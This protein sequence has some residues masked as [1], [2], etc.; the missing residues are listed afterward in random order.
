MLHVCQ[1]M[2]CMDSESE[3]KMYYYY[4]TLYTHLQN[5]IECCI[6]NGLLQPGSRSGKH[7]DPPEY[8]AMYRTQEKAS[9]EKT[10]VKNTEQ[11]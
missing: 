9:R 8:I 2:S 10:R 7:P 1:F 11:L 3:I 5:I 4:Y 6:H